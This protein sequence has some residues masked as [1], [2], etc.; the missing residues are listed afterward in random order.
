MYLSAILLGVEMIG[1]VRDR[2]GSLCVEL[3]RWGQ[4][5]N[6]IRESGAASELDELLAAVS[7]ER[8]DPE[9]ALV[10]LE[11]IGEAC[12]RGG[13]DWPP[14][15]RFRSLPPGMSAP[16]AVESW[17]CPRGYCDRVVLADETGDSRVCRTAGRIPMRSFRLPP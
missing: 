6:F 17:V 1:E 12:K 2:L 7:G 5:E 9:R 14:R 15:S 4:L 10:L 3:S 8:L 16:P 13:L 11:G